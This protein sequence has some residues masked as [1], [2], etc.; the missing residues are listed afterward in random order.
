EEFV[1]D[2]HL[3]PD[4]N[5]LFEHS[6][7]SA[8][9]F[10]RHHDL[11]RNRSVREITAPAALY[12][13]SSSA[14]VAR[15]DRRNHAFFEKELQPALIESLHISTATGFRCATLAGSATSRGL[16]WLVGNVLQIVVR[17]A[18]AGGLKF[19]LNLRRSGHHHVFAAKLA[20]EFVEL[21]VIV[22]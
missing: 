13:H 9:V 6:P 3:E 4:R 5:L 10:D 21:L 15:F 8:I 19:S 14:A 17:V 7:N 2:V 1:L 20:A 18:A 22:D 11:R 12:E 16:H